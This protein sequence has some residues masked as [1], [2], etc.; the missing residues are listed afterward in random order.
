MMS[1]K[2]IPPLNYKYESSKEIKIIASTALTN[3]V[4]IRTLVTLVT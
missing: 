4:I 1:L 2:K 3:I